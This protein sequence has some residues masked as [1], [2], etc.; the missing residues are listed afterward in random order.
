VVLNKRYQK[1]EKK[2]GWRSFLPTAV[3]PLAGG[4]EDTEDSP[5]KASEKK[6]LGRIKRIHTDKTEVFQLKRD[7]ERTV[8]G[9]IQIIV[10]DTPIT[11]INV[12]YMVYGCDLRFGAGEPVDFVE[13]DDG[14]CPPARERV[15]SVFIFTTMLT[16]ALATKKVISFRSLGAKKRNRERLEREIR[17]MEE[18]AGV[19]LKELV[20]ERTGGEEPPAE[21]MRGP[22]EVAGGGESLKQQVAR[23]TRE[24]EAR[25]DEA[26]EKA[27][28]AEEQR[29]R[30]EKAEQEVSV[31]RKRVLGAEV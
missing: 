24:K 13:L 7:R 14:G 15:G 10:E 26:R 18:E 17:G 3:Q 16:V 12:L 19:W 6:L 20:R 5:V 4:G 21:E 11:L 25:A 2:A 23:L 29:Q 9:V 28:Q 31:L 30:A 27:A 22:E 1:S 8:A